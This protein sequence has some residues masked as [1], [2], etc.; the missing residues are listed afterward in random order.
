MKAFCVFSVIVLAPNLSQ[1]QVIFDSFG[2]NSGCK[3]KNS[4][5]KVRFSQGNSESI[6]LSVVLNNYSFLPKLE[7]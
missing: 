4:V 6:L 7:M 5:F 2:E 3:T 1:C